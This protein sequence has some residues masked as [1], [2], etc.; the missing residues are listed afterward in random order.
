MVH[1]AMACTS[2]GHHQQEEKDVEEEDVV[3]VA[4]AAHFGGFV[5][6]FYMHTIGTNSMA[7]ACTKFFSNKHIYFNKSI[8]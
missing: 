2:R 8:I 6:T 7:I 4:A 5:S 3:V 1:R